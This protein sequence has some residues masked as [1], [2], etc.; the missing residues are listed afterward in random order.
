MGLAM[1]LSRQQGAEA[2]EQQNRGELARTLPTQPQ[3]CLL[4]PPS[5]MA[6]RYHKT[7][8]QNSTPVLPLF[9]VRQSVTAKSM[10]RASTLSKYRLSLP[11]LPR[12]AFCA[13]SYPSHYPVFVQ[14][15]VCFREQAVPRAAGDSFSGFACGKKFRA[16][17]HLP[18]LSGLLLLCSVRGRP[19]VSMR[20]ILCWI[21]AMLG[22]A[23]SGPE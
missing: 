9:G 8:S 12:D 16:F 19:P 7:P 4:D 2:K 18:V 15:L 10:S 21:G 13:S 17:F 20:R 23:N 1:L 22:C 6:E 14:A 5:A 3:G 11:A